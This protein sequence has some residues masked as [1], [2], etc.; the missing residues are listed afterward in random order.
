MNLDSILKS[1]ETLPTKVHIVKS[2][3]FPVVVYGCES[4]TIKKTAQKN[5]CL[6][7][8][9]LEETLES[10]LDSK[11]MKPV[12][13]TGNQPGIFTGRTDAKAEPPM[14]WP[15]DAKSWLIRKD[16]DAGKDWGQEEKGM[17]EDETVGW[18]H[19]LNGHKFE[20]TLGDVEGQRVCTSVH[21]V[22]KESDTTERLNNNPYDEKN[23]LCVC[24]C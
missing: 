3:V 13:L 20:Q 5:W 18:H 22:T 14:L 21:R 11:D 2:V 23:V 19:Q 24:V 16:P 10:L 8:V 4:W 7:T 6:R 12:N 15:P 1:R 9:G 17:T